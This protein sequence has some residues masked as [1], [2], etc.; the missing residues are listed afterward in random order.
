MKIQEY[1]K[2]EEQEK[3]QCESMTHYDQN[4][5]RCKFPASYQIGE[6]LLCKVHAGQECL[7]LILE[8][9]NEPDQHESFINQ[10]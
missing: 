8:A 10:Q 3:P 7:K 5:T 9:Y 4:N 2:L 6:K 1:K